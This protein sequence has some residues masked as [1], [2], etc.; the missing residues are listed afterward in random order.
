MD[1]TEE[2]FCIIPSNYFKKQSMTGNWA[3]DCHLYGVS[4]LLHLF[5]STSLLAQ[6]VPVAQHTLLPAHLQPAVRVLE[7]AR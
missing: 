4:Y 1:I 2:A 7:A 6:L 3:T 5:L